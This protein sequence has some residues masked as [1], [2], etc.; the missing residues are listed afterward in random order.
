MCPICHDA[1]PADASRHTLDE[2]GHAFHAA[3]LIGW[4][5]TG[6]MSCPCCRADLEREEARDSIDAFTLFERASYLRTTVARRKS[7]PAD[8]LR[9]VDRVRKAEAQEKA[10]VRALRAYNREHHT[11]IA[12]RSRLRSSSYRWSGIVRDA[13]RVLGM[14]DSPHYPLPALIVRSRRSP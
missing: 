5:R 6:G 4:L 8:L 14:Y 13:K 1:L 2:C 11:V 3:C 7:A 12:Q 10:C 9:L